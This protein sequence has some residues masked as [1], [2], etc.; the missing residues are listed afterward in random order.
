M[1]STCNHC[2]KPLEQAATGRPRKFCN[3]A[4]R[5]KARRPRLGARAGL[6]S[7]R[8][9]TPRAAPVPAAQTEPPR[10]RP[11]ARTQGSPGRA[12]AL[13]RA[14]AK[15]AR[16]EQALAEARAA[17]AALVPEFGHERHQFA[18]YGSVEEMRAAHG[19]AVFNPGID[20]GKAADAIRRQHEGEQ[21]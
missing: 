5:A 13:G 10:E 21:G 12:M 15:V 7:G 19:G 14:E 18:T 4:C 11:L 6:V 2:G 8:P 20:V 17:R 1:S 3:E 9:E 16:C